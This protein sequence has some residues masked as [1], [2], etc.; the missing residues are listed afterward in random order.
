MHACW[1]G[2]RKHTC[3]HTYIHAGIHTFTYHTCQVGKVDTDARW[4]TA[5]K[6]SEIQPEIQHVGAGT[7]DGVPKSPTITMNDELILGR[8]VN[9]TKFQNSR[10]LLSSIDDSSCSHLI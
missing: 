3:I 4:S 10:S 7:A 2:A 5:A 6:K 1:D 9:C 8:D